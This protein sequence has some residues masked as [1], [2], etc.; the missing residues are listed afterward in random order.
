METSKT[1]LDLWAELTLAVLS[2]PAETMHCYSYCVL[3]L[4]RWG[5]RDKSGIYTVVVLKICIWRV[6]ELGHS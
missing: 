5:L 3:E 6:E 4:S 2:L 1:G